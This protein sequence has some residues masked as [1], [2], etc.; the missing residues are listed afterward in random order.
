MVQGAD[1]R[2]VQTGET[3]STLPVGAVFIFIGQTP[4]SHL[5]RGLVELDEGG[6]ARVDLRMQHDRPGPVRRVV[7]CAWMRRDNW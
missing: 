2:N 5:L 6:H 3:L 1:L 4:N 7:I